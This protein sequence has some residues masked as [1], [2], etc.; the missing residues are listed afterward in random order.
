[1]T[2][3]RNLLIATVLLA[4]THPGVS[5]AEP[6]EWVHAAGW[7]ASEPAGPGMIRG[8]GAGVRISWSDAVAAS[9]AVQ[10]LKRAE[11]GIGLSFSN[12]AL[13]NGF[14]GWDGVHLPGLDRV[15]GRNAVYRLP[16]NPPLLGLDSNA[17]SASCCRRSNTL[18]PLDRHASAMTAL[19]A[20][21]TIYVFAILRK[22]RWDIE[23]KDGWKLL[24]G[25]RSMEYSRTLQ[26]RVGFLTVERFWESFRASYSFQLERSTG[27]NLAPSQAL[28]LDYHYSP[29][30]SIGV[31]YATGREFADFG[32]LGILNTE[33]R[34][35]GVRGQH[36]FKKD[37]AF[38]FLAG[39]SDHGSL[40]AYQAVRLGLQ[41]SF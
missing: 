2:H 5:A 13:V 21:S 37:W 10:P 15:A 38:T 3:L 36:W 32:T 4:A 41:R 29:R 34:S 22:K 19:P 27:L 24:A 17:L 8:N 30:D 31:S 7:K 6:L 9:Y 16:R 39:H 12:D 40:P 35:V 11:I 28:L 14:T 18:T 1:M 26:T 33:V 23:F 25:S 20:V